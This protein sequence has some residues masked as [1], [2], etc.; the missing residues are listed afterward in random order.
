MLREREPRGCRGMPFFADALGG[1]RDPNNIEKDFR[2]VPC[3]DAVRVGGATH[4]WIGS[5]K[6]VATLLDA[7]GL[8][9]RTI[10]DQLGLRISMTQDVYMG[11]RAVDAAARPHSTPLFSGPDDSQPGLFAAS[12]AVCHERW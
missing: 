2:A 9:A 1:Y 6:T 3:W 10:A 8:S 4:R 5:R 11:R 12:Q 7:G